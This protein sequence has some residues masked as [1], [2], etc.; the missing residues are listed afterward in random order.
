[1]RAVAVLVGVRA[2][3]DEVG[4]PRRAAPELRVVYKDTRVDDVREGPGA[5]ALVVPVLRPALLPVGDA[6]QPPRR[7]ALRYEGGDADLDVGLDVGDL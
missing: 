7:Y 6:R 3:V 5:G 2:A 1:M 4:A